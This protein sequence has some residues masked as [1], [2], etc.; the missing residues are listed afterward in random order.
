MKR[1]IFSK[2]AYSAENLGKGL[3]KKKRK[4]KRKRKS[5]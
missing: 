2:N 5:R 4:R 3:E 1:D